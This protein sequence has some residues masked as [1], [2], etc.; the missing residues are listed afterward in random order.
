MSPSISRPSTRVHE[1]APEFLVVKSVTFTKIRK[2]CAAVASAEWAPFASP[3]WNLTG[4]GVVLMGPTNYPTDPVTVMS[5]DEA[6]LLA[7]TLVE[8]GQHY[9]AGH[10]GEWVLD[11]CTVEIV[12]APNK[13][14]HDMIGDFIVV[15]DVMYGKQDKCLVKLTLTREDCD[16]VASALRRMV[17]QLKKSRG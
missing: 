14:I 3:P 8:V 7:E 5:F 15:K 9:D 16:P 1:I 13:T 6:L 11:G 17:R 10:K 12:D 2:L 4:P